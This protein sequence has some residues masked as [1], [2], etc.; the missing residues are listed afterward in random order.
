[1]N[2]NMFVISPIQTF[3]DTEVT[4]LKE[5]TKTV[6]IASAKY[7][8]ALEKKASLPANSPKYSNVW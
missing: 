2:L 3:L 7:H 4:L 8:A 6:G 5:S 1:M